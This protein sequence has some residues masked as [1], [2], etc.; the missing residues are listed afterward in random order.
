MTFSVNAQADTTNHTLSSTNTVTDTVPNNAQD[1]EVVFNPTHITGAYNWSID[2]N[3][4]NYRN[5]PRSALFSSDTLQ[6]SGGSTVTFSIS[7]T[8]T[9]SV[10]QYD[11]QTIYNPIITTNL[12]D[13]NFDNKVDFTLYPNPTVN[14]IN[15][16]FEN[17][18]QNNVTYNIFDISGRMVMQGNLFNNNINVSNLNRG[19]Y[20][21]NLPE[22]RVNKKFVKR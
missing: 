6:L 22:M 20:F 15:V 21:I 11:I 10:G 2:T 9:G 3:G 8:S 5:G 1:Y 4:V 7:P 13:N 16:K 14:D 18:N 12:S 19:T 17:S